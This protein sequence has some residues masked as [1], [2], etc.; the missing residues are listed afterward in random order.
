MENMENIGT[1]AQLFLTQDRFNHLQLFPERCTCSIPASTR[2]EKHYECIPSKR[3]IGLKYNYLR[4]ARRQ[5]EKANK[6]I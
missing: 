3:K 1:L 5:F 6:I 4:R 2:R